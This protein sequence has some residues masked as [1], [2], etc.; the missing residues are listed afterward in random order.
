MFSNCDS[1]PYC[2]RLIDYLVFV[3]REGHSHSEEVYN[4][5]PSI[6]K[7]YPLLKHKDFVLPNDVVYF[8]QPEGCLSS[9]LSSTNMVIPFITLVLVGNYNICVYFD[10]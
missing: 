3:G 6:L 1:L 9:N 4:Q 7:C 5:I 2:P 10:G 8:C